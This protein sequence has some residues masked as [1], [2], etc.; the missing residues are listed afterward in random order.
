MLAGGDGWIFFL[1]E[2]VHGCCLDLMKYKEY[3]QLLQWKGMEHVY[4]LE[5][6]Q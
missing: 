5:V 6:Y 4:H 3:N 1:G 2:W